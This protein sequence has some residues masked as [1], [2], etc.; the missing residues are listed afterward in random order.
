MGAR[1]HARLVAV[2]WLTCQIVAYAAAPFV[3]CNDH[4]VMSGVGSGHE[5][6][7]RHHHHGQPAQQTTSHENHHHES[8]TPTTT[9]ATVD[10]RCTVSDTA[11]AALTLESGIMTTE[12]VLDTK[13]VTVRVAVPDHVA[14]TRIQSID[15]PPPRA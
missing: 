3:L 13:L 2:V 9:D 15:T 4:G 12:F 8:D 5:C 7:P 11:L 1:A 10:C 6:D 14:P